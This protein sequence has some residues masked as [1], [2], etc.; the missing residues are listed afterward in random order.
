MRLITTGTAAR[1]VG[2]AAET[3]R[4]YETRGL[5][6]PVRDSSGRRLLTESDVERI[7]E[8]RQRRARSDSHSGR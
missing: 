6:A 2:V 5:I 3:I 4:N 8:F 7:K 1:E